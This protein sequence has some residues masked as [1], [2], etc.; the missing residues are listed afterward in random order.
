VLQL[1]NSG[2]GALIYKMNYLD[3]RINYSF[4]WEGLVVRNFII[5]CKEAYFLKALFCF[6]R[7]V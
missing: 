3:V 2:E 1:H 5:L 6:Q 4:L 7:N